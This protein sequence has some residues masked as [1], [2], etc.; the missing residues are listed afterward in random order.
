MI[1][2]HIYVTA[3]K[4]KQLEL[5]QAITFLKNRIDQEM[6]CTSYR[7]YQS[8]DTEDEFVIFEEWVNEKSARTHLESDN[9]TVLVG[10][11]SVLA[12]K[13][14]VALSNDPSVR[15]LAGAFKE[16]INVFSNA[17]DKRN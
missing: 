8:I 4:G 10:A 1:S 17:H 2:V 14:C 7:V 13:V 9:L 12:Q 3:K 6:G 16:R 11:G 15:L 5:K